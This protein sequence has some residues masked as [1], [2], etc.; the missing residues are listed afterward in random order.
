M[1][2]SLMTQKANAV[3]WMRH[4]ET[5]LVSQNNETHVSRLPIA[6]LLEIE[7]ALLNNFRSLITP[8]SSHH[9]TTTANQIHGI[10][11]K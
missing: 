3:R 5:R 2:D 1:V 6:Q 10:H 11:H 7:L 9:N 8:S 4:Q